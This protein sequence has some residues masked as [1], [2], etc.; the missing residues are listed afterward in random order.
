MIV[1]SKKNYYNFAWKTYCIYQKWVNIM[2][3]DEM[4]TKLNVSSKRNSKTAVR[5]LW[6]ELLVIE[7][8]LQPETLINAWRNNPNARYD[9]MFGRDSID[10]KSTSSFEREHLFSPGRLNLPPN[11]RLLIASVCV[12]EVSKECGG[13]SVRGLYDKICS[14]VSDIKTMM[15]LNS[16]VAGIVGCDK[17][18]ADGVFFD[19]VTASSTLAFFDSTDV[20]QISKASIPDFVSDVW[21][22]CNISHLLSIEEK[23]DYDRS[24]SPLFKS[25][26]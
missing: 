9:F 26:Y 7:R 5:E 6:A 20:P 12:M 25:L 23:G 1:F 22:T 11:S 2:N 13:V 18:F 4:Y 17:C 14:K 15:K 3:T 10:V 16:I 19:Y 21:F 24:K 8:S